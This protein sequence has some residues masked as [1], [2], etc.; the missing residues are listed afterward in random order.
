MP[1]KLF[2]PGKE[3]RRRRLVE[4]ATSKGRVDVRKAAKALKL[5]VDEV[6]EILSHLTGFYAGENLFIHT[7]QEKLDD[8]LSQIREKG[9]AKL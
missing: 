6:R 8:A 7:P 1:L 3:E 5:S 4:M 2:G 9:R